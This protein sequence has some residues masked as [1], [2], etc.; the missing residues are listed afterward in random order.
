VE[1]DLKE[2]DKLVLKKSVISTEAGPPGLRRC[3]SLPLLLFYGLGTILGAGIYVLVGQVAGYA[4]HSAPLS[5]LIAAVVAGFTG[6]SYAELSARFPLNAGEA[7]YM[8]EAF[9]IPFWAVLIGLLVAFSGIISAAAVTRGAAGYIQVFINLPTPVLIVSSLLILGVIAVW[10]TTESLTI[11]AIFTLIEIGGLVMII[12]VGR[13]A[14][15]PSA[16]NFQ[17]FIPDIENANWGGIIFGGFLAFF[18]YI[19]FEDMVNVAEEVKNPQRNL[20]LAILL[21]LFIATILYLLISIVAVH[22]ASAGELVKSD[23][24]LAFLFQRATGQNPWLV[25]IISIFAVINGALI[26]IIMASRMLYGMSRRNWLPGILSKVHP[27]TH[28]PLYATITIVGLVLIFALFLPLIALASVTSFVLL[29]VFILINLAL[30]KLKMDK[31]AAPDV[32]VYP[33]WVPVIGA[34]SCCALVVSQLISL[35]V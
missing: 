12:W 25:S 31:L 33:I 27:Q 2:L 11:A 35:L 18:A 15:S 7:V 16:F 20:P 17:D 4:G 26:Q 22:L 32:R 19:G 10:G 34:L 3:I 30:I 6:I 23:A 8:Q 14:F 9:G 28:T 29:I 24:P 13:E 21:S 1:P 5:F